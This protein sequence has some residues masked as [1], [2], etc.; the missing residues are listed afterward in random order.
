MKLNE[1]Q[2][3]IVGIIK[4]AFTNKK[5]LDKLSTSDDGNLLFNGNEIKGG[6]SADIDVDEELSLESEN[7]VQNKVITERLNKINYAQDLVNSDLDYCYADLLDSITFT[8]N[9]IVPF[10]KN[11]SNGIEYDETNH[12]F[13][14]LKDKTYKIS[15]CIVS[16]SVSSAGAVRYDLINTDNEIICKYFCNSVAPNMNTSISSGIGN[17]IYTPIKDEYIQIKTSE[18]RGTGMATGPNFGNNYLIIEEVGKAIVIDPLK[19]ANEDDGIEDSPVGHIMSYM[20]VNPPKHYLACDGTEYNITD[21]PYLTQFI[22]NEFGT[23]N[24]FGGDGINTFAVPDLR[25]EFLRGSGTNSHTSQGNGGTVGEHQ[26]GTEF[27]SIVQAA[28]RG[29]LVVSQRESTENAKQENVDFEF[30]RNGYRTLSL[31]GYITSVLS[32]F[33]GYTSRPTNTSVLYCIKYEPTYYMSN[34]IDNLYI[35]GY[36]NYSE[37]EHIVGQWID[38]KP[39]YEKN[40]TETVKSGDGAV[41]YTFDSDVEI[42]NIINNPTYYVN[43]AWNVYLRKSSNENILV[44]NAGSSVVGTKCNVTI[45]YTKTTDAENSFTPDMITNIQVNNSGG[46]SSPLPSEP[47]EEIITDEDMNNAIQETL[48]YL[49]TK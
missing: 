31:N 36:D 41:F 37:E 11:K 26:D 23:V 29:S 7:P 8:L 9:R 27:P 33:G 39:L 10:K 4:G 19:H 47:S 20:G 12:S 17:I 1:V 45:Q 22:I 16:A 14:L 44:T 38:G 2:S 40:I 30:G 28:N 48:D 25:G 18:V 34:T 21:C 32:N 15:S 49:K 13:K 42:K 43:S 24:Y 3:L 6:G 46:S 5:T 35:K